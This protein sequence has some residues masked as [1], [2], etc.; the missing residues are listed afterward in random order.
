MVYVLELENGKWYVGFTRSKKRRLND[1]FDGYGSLWTKKHKP[2]RVVEQMNG[3]RELE[4]R[5]TI[6]YMRRY[7]WQ[8]VRGYCWVEPELK[9]PPKSLAGYPPTYGE[10]GRAERAARSEGLGGSAQQPA[11]TPADLRHETDTDNWW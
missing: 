9:R 4:R 11:L 8:N 5:K 7:G 1:H 10:D 2:I 6:E 3:G